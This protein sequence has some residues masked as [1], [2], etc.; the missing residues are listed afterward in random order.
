MR[1]QA[2]TVCFLMEARL[3]RDGFKQHCCEL[4]CPNKLIVKK[5][6]SGGGLALI[7]KEEVQL[8]VINYTNNHVLAKVIE[9]DGFQWFLT[10]FYGWSEMT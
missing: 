2:P 10:G 4:A 7:W 5:P 6:D 1:D 9:D 3:D 8:E